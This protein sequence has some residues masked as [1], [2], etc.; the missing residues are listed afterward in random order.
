MVWNPLKRFG[1]WTTL[2]RWREPIAFRVRLRG[3]MFVRLG[4]TL[5]AGLVLTTAIVVVLAINVNPPTIAETVAWVIG[6]MVVGGGLAAGGL[7]AGAKTVSG[8]VRVCEE[9]VV[10]TRTWS[11]F[12]LFHVEELNW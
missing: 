10:R 3:D 1:V 5:A 12:Q 9:G 8:D 4:V 11:S 2:L 6:G 7:F